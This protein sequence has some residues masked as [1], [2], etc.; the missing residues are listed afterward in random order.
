MMNPFPSLPKRFSGEPTPSAGKFRIRTNSGFTLLEVLLSLALTFLLLVSVYQGIF[1]Y[2]QLTNQAEERF[3]RFQVARG[4]YQKMSADITATVPPSE[5]GMSSFTAAGTADGSDESTSDSDTD[6]DSETE[7]PEPLPVDPIDLIS[8]GNFGLV[9]DDRMLILVVDRPQKN[10]M[11]PVNEDAEEEQLLSAWQ[12]RNRRMIAYFL[13]ETGAGGLPDAVAKLS[14]DDDLKDERIKGFA[15]LETPLVG[16]Q[17]QVTNPE[18]LLTNQSRILAKEVEE[19]TFTYF[20]GLEWLETWDSS[21]TG[22]LPQAVKIQ[23]NFSLDESPPDGMTYR[24]VGL[25]HE[26][27]IYLQRSQAAADPLDTEL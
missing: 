26:W 23:L 3:E 4:L 7:E 14:I 16:S 17:M 19:L 25:E 1:L 27:T 18:E 5:S 8:A 2:F 24:S 15:R 9:G 13:A 6:S 22:A 21:I 10:K 12:T 11:Q 20:D